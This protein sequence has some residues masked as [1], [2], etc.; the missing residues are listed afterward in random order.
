MSRC[1]LLGQI[2]ISG[3]ESGMTISASVTATTSAM[4]TPGAV[5]SRVALPS[6][7]PITAISVTTK[8]TGRVDVSGRVH[9][10][11]IFDLPFAACCMATITRLAPLTRSIAPPIP[12]TIL[13][14]IIQLARCPCASTCRPPR[15]VKSTWPPRINPKDIALSKVLAPGR[16]LIGRPDANR[17]D[18][19][20]RHDHGV[21]RHRHDGVEVTRRQRV[22]EVAEV[23]CQ[24][25]VN[26]GELRPQRGL[27]QKRRP[28]YL[29]LAL[30]FCHQRA[31]AG[32]REHP[33][34]T[35]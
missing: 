10:A 19:L 12:G 22:G 25:C 27:E 16:A 20:R 28:V 3:T 7:K 5:S 24:K 23:I 6:G 26:Q 9:L 18:V 30:A 13:P 31:N 17:H 15:T 8:F 1:A 29:D 32:W 11:T 21:G 34:E 4:L 35:A 2:L 14:G 33:S